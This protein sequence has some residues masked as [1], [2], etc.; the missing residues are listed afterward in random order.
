MAT[1]TN[2]ATL[3]YNGNT[4]VSNTV[5]GEILEVI[6]ASK[7]AIGNTYGVNDNITYAIN[8][9]NSGTTALSGLTVTDNLGGYD[10]GTDE[11]VPLDYVEG[12]VRYFVNGVLQEAPTVTA[13]PP[14][15]F[16]GIDVPA[17][18]NAAIVYEVSTNAFASPETDGVITNEA[19]ISG[20]GI[21]PVT[22]S[23]TVTSREEADLRITK[24][25]SPTVVTENGEITYT[26]TIQNFGNAA[27]ATDNA[28]LSD[29]FDPILD[30]TSVTFNGEPWTSPADY[31]Y[32]QTTG[33]FTSVPGRITVPAATFT[34]NPDGSFTVT[35][36]EAT[37][38]IVG[39][40]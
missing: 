28:V 37:L 11:L 2:V 14:L 19:V 36:G 21:T 24:A 3:T 6:S 17:L 7:T 39:T 34:Q 22:V 33:L 5:V 4:A 40:I 29:T 10:F 16:S 8:L 27:V 32:N 9:I 30:I 13:G 31:S 38:V 23:E 15:V 18:S 20:A 35:P 1:F 25:L 26:F 12:S